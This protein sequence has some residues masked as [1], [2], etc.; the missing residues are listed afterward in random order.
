LPDIDSADAH[1]PLAASEYANSIYDYY[2]RVEPK[3]SVSHDYMK[4]QVSCAGSPAHD[5]IQQA[6]ITDH[7][8]PCICAFLQVEINEKMRGILIDWLVEVH[9]KFKV[10]QLPGHCRCLSFSAGRP[11]AAIRQLSAPARVCLRH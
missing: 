11:P 1:N 2:R 5:T 10:R 8:Q 3:F 6:A 4:N 9:L 7:T